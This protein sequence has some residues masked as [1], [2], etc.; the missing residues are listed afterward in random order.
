MKSQSLIGLMPMN[1]N[2]RESIIGQLVLITGYNRIIFDKLGDVELLKE[3]A[4][5]Y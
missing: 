5:H 4:A 2:E 1:N 3:L